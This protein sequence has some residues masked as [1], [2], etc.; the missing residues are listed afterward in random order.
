MGTFSTIFYYILMAILISIIIA[1]MFITRFESKKV[2]PR[3]SLLDDIL[4]F[5]GNPVAY[6]YFL[7]VCLNPSNPNPKATLETPT[8]MIV[9][10]WLIVS[11]TIFLVR[12]YKNRKNKN[13]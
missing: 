6:G 12:Y 1:L 11:S 3:Y 8:S 13:H 9:V 7:F 4:L 5:S 2:N 10:A